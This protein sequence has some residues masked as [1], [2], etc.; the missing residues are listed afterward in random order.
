[1]HAVNRVSRKVAQLNV[2]DWKHVKRI[3]RYLRG[4]STLGIRYV[5]D[6]PNLVAFCDADFAGD[7]ETQQST[8]GYIILLGKGSIHWKSQRQRHVTVSSTEAEY[9]AL[10]TTSKEVAWLRKIAIE[11][12]IIESEPILLQCDYQSAMRTAQS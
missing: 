4:Y 1:M 2:A 3:L 9:V 5:K 6:A 12:G 8:T 10:C 7:Q 11:L